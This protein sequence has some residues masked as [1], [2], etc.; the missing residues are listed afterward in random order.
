MS[1]QTNGKGI[2]LASTPG[3]DL[4]T[5][6]SGGC[7]DERL[8]LSIIEDYTPSLRERYNP[9]LTP[10]RMNTY[11]NIRGGGPVIVNWKSAFFSSRLMVRGCSLARPSPPRFALVDRYGRSRGESQLR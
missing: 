6:F 2:S 9:A 8:G 5:M 7:W 1:R 11:K 10:F 4:A 3:L